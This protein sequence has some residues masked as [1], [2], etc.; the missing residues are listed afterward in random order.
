MKRGKPGNKLRS[1]KVLVLPL[2]RNSDALPDL[3]CE[4]DSETIAFWGRV[5]LGELRKQGFHGGEPIAVHDIV[6]RRSDTIQAKTKRARERIV[7]STH[8]L[9]DA[10]AAI[11][12][13]G[14]YRKWGI[15]CVGYE[16]VRPFDV[17]LGVTGTVE[18]GETHLEA[19]QRE[20]QE[21]TGLCIDRMAL[22]CTTW[23][24]T[25]ITRLA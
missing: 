8:G 5:H 18:K 25:Y 2:V 6:S 15:V 12:Q 14:D 21:E 19:A 22:K 7:L 1:H 4:D 23:K 3:R 24:G 10:A 17:Q 9:Y 16:D 13:I 20:L 11:L